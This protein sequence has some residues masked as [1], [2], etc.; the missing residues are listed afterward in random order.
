MKV[1]HETHQLPQDFFPKTLSR[2]PKK[3]GEHPTY[4]NTLA[5]WYERDDSIEKNDKTTIRKSYHRQPIS[6]AQLMED[7]ADTARQAKL[8]NI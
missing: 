1:K 8:K 5:E 4:E 6:K 3:K 2:S 7:S